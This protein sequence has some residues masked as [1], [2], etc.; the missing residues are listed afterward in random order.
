MAELSPDGTRFLVAFPLADNRGEGQAVVWDVASGERLAVPVGADLRAARFLPDGGLAV[1]SGEGG[2]LWAA[3]WD[4]A[5]RRR[6]G[7]PTPGPT[8]GGACRVCRP[9]PTWSRSSR[10]RRPSAACPGGTARC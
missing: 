9:A 2:R 5:G 10:T 3:V 6:R 4:L 1:V 7:V 8:Q